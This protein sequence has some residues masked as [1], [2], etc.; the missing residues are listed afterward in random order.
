MTQSPTNTVDR[1]LEDLQK[2][3]GGIDAVLIWPTYPNRGIDDRNQHDMICPMPGGI[4]GVR[5]MVV[6][7]FHR[8]GVR[9]LFPMMMWDQGTRDPGMPW[10]E[11]LPARWGK[12]EPTVLTATLTTEFPRLFPWRPT[13]VVIRSFL[14]RRAIPPDDALA[15]DLPTWGQYDYSF[16]PRVDKYKWLE[17]RHLV[18][19][20]NR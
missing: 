20:S 4:P 19:I 14:S 6:A 8:H 11:R 1:S 18:D 10:P 17:T 16:V 13:Q 9:V 12:S 7:D 2:R 5:Q 15:W 3:Y